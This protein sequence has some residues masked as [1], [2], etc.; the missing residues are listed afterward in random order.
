MV[1]YKPGS[2]PS[3]GTDLVL[4]FQ[5]PKL[6]ESKCLLFKPLGLQYFSIAAKLTK[7]G[8]L[9]EQIGPQLGEKSNEE[10]C[11]QLT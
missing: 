4:D 6:Q 11:F 7:T 10:V 1:I 5:L 8:I 2:K 3:S 9:Q